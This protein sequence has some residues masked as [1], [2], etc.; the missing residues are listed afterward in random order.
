MKTLK[1][2]QVLPLLGLL[3]A[4]AGHI[5]CVFWR[6]PQHPD[7]TFQ[8]IEPAQWR[9]HGQG[10][11]AWEWIR[12]ARS[13]FL[14]AVN[15]VLLQL[16]GRLPLTPRQEYLSLLGAWSLASIPAIAFVV[17]RLSS[18]H[19]S[20][21][22]RHWFRFGL[23]LY[24]G[25][26]PMLLSFAPHILSELA[27]AY[28]LLL[29]YSIASDERWQL[30]TAAVNIDALALGALCALAAC[31][32]VSVL[33]AAMLPL[34]VPVLRRRWLQAQIAA[35]AFGVVVLAFGLLDK[36]TWGHMFHSYIEYVRFNVLEHGANE[37]GVE[38]QNWYVQKY[39]AAYSAPLVIG[40]SL[41]HL[42]MLPR[43]WLWTVGGGMTIA[44]LSMQPHKET[45]FVLPAL[46]LLAVPIAACMGTV[47]E[48]AARAR[49]S[50]TLVAAFAIALGLGASFRAEYSGRV[51]VEDRN[52][53][54]LWG[55]IDAQLWAAGRPDVTG[56]AF[57]ESAYCGVGSGSVRNV[58][59]SPSYLVDDN[60]ALFNYR[61]VRG[62]ARIDWARSLHMQE[63][64]RS[65][66]FVVFR[67]Q[68]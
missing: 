14:P 64:L 37:F 10:V 57:D 40:A 5:A 53:V 59:F 12:G 55:L 68:D 39:M 32:R 20:A 22:S 65:E 28:L 16:L 56:I 23:W 26:S 21:G 47:M 41:V 52:C 18:T 42:V 9:L 27:S 62:R 48:R 35:A 60:N 25:L 24:L 51:L 8:Y 29:A 34:L 31:V 63:L 4:V 66:D 44:L 36:L 15:G 58:P 2:S 6:V 38:P 45:R 43:Y 11:A 49:R 30:R 19:A 50:I 61:I 67:R 1:F 33:P 3:L 17:R 13:W 46:W 7:E 54:P